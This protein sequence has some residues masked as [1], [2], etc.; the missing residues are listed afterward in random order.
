MEKENF[1][2]DK[3]F[4]RTPIVRIWSYFHSK[5]RNSSALGLESGLLWKRDRNGNVKPEWL[6]PA[7]VLMNHFKSSVLKD[8]V[9]CC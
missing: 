2:A 6:S 7:G 4:Y 1:S 9:D 8:H 3:I 5:I